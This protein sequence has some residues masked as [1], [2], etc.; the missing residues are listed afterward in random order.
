MVREYTRE[1]E[2][3]IALVF[4]N[5]APGRLAEEAYERAIRLAASIAWHFYE[6]HTELS[7]LAPG[8]APEA[9]VYCFLE[10]LALAA[11]Q[12]AEGDLL[13]RLPRQ[14]QYNII[15]TA[16]ERGGIPTSLWQSS[17][18]LFLGEESSGL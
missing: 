11:P 15:L 10:Y 6:Q 3:R 18:V 13:R 2:R 7:F 5:P 16:A 17:W 9:D 8:L 14:G 1:D 12:A 4:D